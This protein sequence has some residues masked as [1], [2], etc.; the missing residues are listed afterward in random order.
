MCELLA[1]VARDPAGLISSLSRFARRGGEEGP[2][3]DGWRVAYYDGYDVRLIREPERAADSPWIPFV[4]GQA[5]PTRL[6]LAPIR[7]ATVGTRELANTQPFVRELGGHMHCFAHN[8]D[9]DEIDRT[10]GA[11]RDRFAPVGSTDSELAFCVLMSRLEPFWQAALGEGERAP[12]AKAR[13]L[14]VA[15]FARERRRFGPANFLYTDGDLLFA[16]GHCRRQEDETIAPPG[17]GDADATPLSREDR[18][19]G[20]RPELALGRAGR[21]SVRQRAAHR[22]AVA[23]ARSQRTGGCRPR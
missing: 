1:M 18:P 10:W 20:R 15:E 13:A 16:H 19:A 21:R 22:R 11:R 6:A 23:L 8:G 4:R 9:L 7:R 12:D 2:H 17:S 5:R 3:A 14:V